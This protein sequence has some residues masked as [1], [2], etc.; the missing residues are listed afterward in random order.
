MDVSPSLMTEPSPQPNRPG[1][2]SRCV[3]LACVLE[4]TARKPGNVFPGHERAGLI[5][6]DFVRS[7]LAIGPVFDLAAQRSIGETVIDAVRD[8]IAEVQTNTNLGIILLIA[9][10]ASVGDGVKLHNGIAEVLSRTSIVDAELVY[11]AIRVAQPG[12]MGTVDD[13]DLSEPPSITLLE[14]MQMAADYD[15]VARQYA[16]GFSDVHQV[17]VRR[18][19]Q[20][21]DQGLAWEDAIIWSY[22]HL[23]AHLPDTLIARKLGQSE[24]ESSQQWARQALDALGKPTAGLADH[25]ALSWLRRWCNKDPAGRNPGTT[26]DLVTASIFWVLRDGSPSYVRRPFR[27]LANTA[28]ST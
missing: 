12:G 26:A 14:V 1:S 24:A 16:N 10:L 13:Q 5:H 21:L 25:S 20:A 19:A 23:M 3:Q 11:E 8:T 18:L 6:L 28:S 17:G 7:A 22:L 4:A 9:P 2:R 27:D 15:A